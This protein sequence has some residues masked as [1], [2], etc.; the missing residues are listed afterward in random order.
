MLS[1]SLMRKRCEFSLFCDGRSSEQ[2][3]G[4]RRRAR[5][6]LRWAAALLLGPPRALTLARRGQRRWAPPHA[7]TA[8]RAAKHLRTTPKDLVGI[9]ERRAHIAAIVQRFSFATLRQLGRSRL[10][11][12]LAND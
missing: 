12:R 8:V 1:R 6:L 5:H 4:R 9:W 3:S 11:Q 10:R 2:S 7:S